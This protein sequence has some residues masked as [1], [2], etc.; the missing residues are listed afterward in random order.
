MRGRLEK[1]LLLPERLL[2]SGCQFDL[3]EDQT[4]L[5]SSLAQTLYRP[6]YLIVSRYEHLPANGLQQLGCI[7]GGA[8]VLGEHR[9][10]LFLDVIPLSIFQITQSLELLVLHHFERLMISLKHQV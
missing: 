8:E 6:E 5:P 10:F 9:G 2:P 1:E 3:G 4:L 7:L